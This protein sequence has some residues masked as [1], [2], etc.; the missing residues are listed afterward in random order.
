MIKASGGKTNDVYGTI[1]D[2]CQ[3]M[4]MFHDIAAK[5]GKNLNNANWVNTV[6]HYGEIVNRGSGQYSSLHTGKYDVEDSFQPPELRLVD[7][8]RR[9]LEVAHPGGEHHGSVGGAPGA[10]RT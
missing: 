8:A 5:A 6:N 10:D 2:A 4:S 3:M 1:S 9:R 7:Q